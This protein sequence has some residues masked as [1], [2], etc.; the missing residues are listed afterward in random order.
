MLRPI[1]S[2]CLI[3]AAIA[4]AAA[5]APASPSAPDDRLTSFADTAELALAAP[6]IVRAT[7]SRANRLTG[8]AAPDVAPG[9]TR[10][11]MTASVSNVLVAP[12]T[13]GGTLQYLRDAPLDARGRPPAVKGLEVLVFL[14][15]PGA[16]GSARL[17]SRRA[18]Q[19]WDSALADTVR[20]VVAEQRSG[21]V[22]IIRGVSNGFR[23]DGTVPGESESQFFLTTADGKPATLVV[24]NRPGEVR[25]VLV[26][27][28]DIIDESAERVRPG[29][30][31]WYR[32][33]C[34]LPARLP[35]AA[36]GDDAALAKDWR[37]ALASLGPCGKTN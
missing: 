1:L 20:A 25:R 37:D 7:I 31:L 35:A 3:L 23:A 36:G 8:K 13:T 30:L 27:R 10:F 32:L 28:G 5:Q 34:F 15:A 9:R 11:L 2:I 16:D 29:T 18:Q 26:A 6:L 21:Q 12:G 17:V 4:P 24:Q 19:A 14:T 33:A 22:P